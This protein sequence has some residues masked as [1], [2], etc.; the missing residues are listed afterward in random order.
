MTQK[1]QHLKHGNWCCITPKEV[2]WFT[3][4]KK[5]Y[6]DKRIP[7]FVR[8]PECNRRLKPHVYDCEDFYRYTKHACNK[9]DKGGGI[10]CHVCVPAHKKK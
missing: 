5:G 1:G 7:K 8:C 4:E 2:S 3:N 10:C 6:R 9:V